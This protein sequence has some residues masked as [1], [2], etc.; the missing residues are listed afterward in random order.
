MGFKSWWQNNMD[1]F[2]I[3]STIRGLFR[4][5]TAGYRQQLQDY[6]GMAGGRQAP[7]M[8]AP[9]YSQFRG[10]Q[11]ELVKMLEAQARGEGPSLATQML[12]AS[13]D[14]G[15]RQQQSMM[16]G[17]R[18]PSAGAGAFMGMNN[19]AGISAQAGQDAA[20]ARMQEQLN[21]QNQ[22]GLTLHGAR[23][24]DEEAMNM[25]RQGNLQSQLATMGMNDQAVIGALTGAGGI[26]GQPSMGER[27]LGG[28]AGMG[29]Q[30]ATGRGQQGQ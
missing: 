30:W 6:A 16:A 21:A 25:T 24:M 26:S 13:S 2:G 1:P 5:P 11:Q 8:A 22:L 23:G 27:L 18:G 3:G 4:D 9:E 19:M 17:M 10:N 29:M 28:L 7:M 14:R 12:E 20:M 15:S